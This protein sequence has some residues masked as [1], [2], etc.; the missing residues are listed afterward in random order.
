MHVKNVRCLS[1]PPNTKGF[2][3]ILR[4]NLVPA[5][6]LLLYDLTL[7][8]SPIGKL[9]LYGPETP[10]GTPSSSMAP[11]LR[12]AIIDMAKMHMKDVP[13]NELASAA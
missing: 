2:Q 3:N 6:G 13:D 7:V 12:A 9:M 4:F 1:A 8:R 11:A 10:Y 5:E